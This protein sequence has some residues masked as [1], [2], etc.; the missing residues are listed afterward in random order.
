MPLLEA[1]ATNDNLRSLRR[2]E[3]DDPPP[4]VSSTESERFDES[5]PTPSSRGGPMPE[6]LKAIIERPIDD[7]EISAISCSFHDIIRPY[8]FYHSEAHRENDRL[9]PSRRHQ[10]T[11]FVSRK[12]C[13][14]MGVIARHCVK[15]RWEKLGV[16]N[17]QWGF[18]GR[19]VQP[20]DDFRMW[21][22]RWQPDEPTE[23]ETQAFRYSRDLVARALRLRQNLRRG[24]HTPVLPRSRLGQ[25][26]TA[27][28]AES[29]LISRP[30]FV[31]EIELAE[32]GQRHCR[33]PFEDQV[34]YPCE[35]RAQV[36]E[37]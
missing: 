27:A 35:I 33:L 36:V 3:R 9:D 11:M 15:R 18:A 16:W 31:F 5:D 23:D 25:D 22:W 14:R 13:R 1:M 26:I 12:G 34:R 28:E 30:W 29:F 6:E 24:E 19:Q 37:W 4:Y 2:F 10:P 8:H 32:E 17:P 7:D 21:R 20:S